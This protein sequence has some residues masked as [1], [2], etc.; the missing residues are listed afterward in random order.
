MSAEGEYL[1]KSAF[2]EKGC[3]TLRLNIRLKSY[4]YHQHLYTVRERNSS[5]QLFRW[6]FPHKET[7]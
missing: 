6:K 2:V 3:V 1:S 4:I 5:L 7:L